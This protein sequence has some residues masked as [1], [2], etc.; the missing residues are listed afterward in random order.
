MTPRE[1]KALR[2]KLGISQQALA[3]QLG[4]H[5][6]TV[7]RWEAGKTPIS[8]LAAKLIQTLH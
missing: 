8:Q 4:V 5:I 3:D 2:A 7:W 1:L 6:M